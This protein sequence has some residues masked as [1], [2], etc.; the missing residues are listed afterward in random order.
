[1]L[2][3]PTQFAIVPVNPG[4][5][6]G[7]ALEEEEEGVAGKGKVKVKPHRDKRTFKFEAP[8]EEQKAK[9]V[10][11]LRGRRADGRHRSDS[12]DYSKL[13]TLATP[14]ASVSAAADTTGPTGS[15]ESATPTTK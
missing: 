13:Y 9:W 8:N 5:G 2:D 12:G 14:R 11:A 1:M 6:S 3:S 4:E 7:A 15:R 10:K